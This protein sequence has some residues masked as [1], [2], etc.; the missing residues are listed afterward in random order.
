MI[1]GNRGSTFIPFLPVSIQST[2]TDVAITQNLTNI[3]PYANVSIP[4]TIA[5]PSYFYKG[6]G[7]IVATAGDVINK[8]DFAV[9]PLAYQFLLPIG[10]GLAIVILLLIVWIRSKH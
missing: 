6:N 3:P 5:I 2:P 8:Y 1:I 7:T 4:L 10:A 9:V